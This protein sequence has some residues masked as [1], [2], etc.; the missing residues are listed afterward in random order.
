[1]WEWECK[2]T[3]I[4]I[5]LREEIEMFLYTTMEMRWKWKCYHGVER[6]GI[7]EVILAHLHSEYPSYTRPMM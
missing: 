1:M 3:G 2:G 5:L 6:N 7:D 4:N